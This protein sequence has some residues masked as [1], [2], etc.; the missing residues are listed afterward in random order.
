[1]LKAKARIRRRQV[2]DALLSGLGSLDPLLARIYAARGTTDPASLDLAASRLLH[3]ARL[4]GLPAAVALLQSALQQQQRLLIVGDYDA[5]GATGTALAVR[6]LKALGYH[7]VDFLAPDRFRYG[8]GLSPAIVE[9]ALERRPDL[10]ITVD[11]GISSIDGVAA[12]KA[13]G[14]RVIVTDHHLPG[15]Q[16][17]QADVLVNPNLPDSAFPSKA[18]AGVG[19]VFYLLLA[20]RAGLREQG[21]FAAPGSE[22]KLV[23]LIDLVALGT[24]ADVVPLDYNNRI[25]VEQGLRRIRSGRANPGIQALL[26]LA[27]RDP[28]RAVAADLGFAAGPRLNAAGRLDDMTLGIQCL[29]EDDP[30]RATELAR[31]LD[32]LNRERRSIESAMQQQAEILLEAMFQGQACWPQGVCLQGEDWHQGVVGIVA[33]RVKDRLHRPV[34]AFASAEDGS[35]KGSGRSIEGLHLRDALDAV[36]SRHPGLI[37]R[38]GGHAMA[39]GLSIDAGDFTAFAQAFDDEV[40]RQLGDQPL[41]PEIHSDGALSANELCLDTAWRLRMAGPWGQHFPEPLFDGRFRVVQRRIVGEQHLKLRLQP[42]PEGPELDAIAFFMA[43]QEQYP[44]DELHAAYRLDIN[45]Y[46]GEQNLQLQIVHIE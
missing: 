15:S 11:N 26:E 9:L 7:Q 30:G 27:G 2:V 6:G 37:Q 19:V 45:H 14:L 18:L 40:R 24:V 10:L 43:E 46:R 13:A 29:L 5:D 12:A 38:F 17:P 20:L 23:E 3:P 36:A 8:Y 44:G 16:L 39:A 31:Q 35:L 34:I 25:L 33:S 22:P 1:M 4:E 28:Q 42:L 41:E 32:R 21:C